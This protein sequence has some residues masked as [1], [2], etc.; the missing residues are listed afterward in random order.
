MRTLEYTFRRKFQG[1]DG[2]DDKRPYGNSSEVP[3]S[4]PNKGETIPCF[5]VQFD[6]A[7]ENYSELLQDIG[8]EKNWDRFVDTIYI[9][10]MKDR[11]RAEIFQK[12]PDGHEN[13]QEGRDDV[14]AKVERLAKEFTYASVIA[15]TLNSKAAVDELNSPEMQELAKSNPAEFTRRA[16]VILASTRGAKAA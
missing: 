7:P 9:N 6:R 12:L 14:I 4:G 11:I 13:T 8:G 15:E 1:P 10:G 2:G 3:E 5:R 16:M